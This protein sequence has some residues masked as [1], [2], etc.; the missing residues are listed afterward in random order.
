M[1]KSGITGFSIKIAVKQFAIRILLAFFRGLILVKRHF[2]PLLRASLSPLLSVGRFLV[3]VIGVPLY[4]VLFAVRRSI[5]RVAGPAKHRALYVVSN[6]YAIHV[7]VV[8]IAAVASTMN[9]G[10]SEVR[11]ESFGQN[12]ML[13][14]LV[15]QG[16]NETV[17][18]V[19]AAADV[20][21][22]K[23]ASYMD[24]V[25]VSADSHIDIGDA[26]SDF[27]STTVGGS[28]I[29]T[30]AIS[31][32]NDSVAPRTEVE[33]YTVQDGDTLSGISDQF[34]LSLSTLL[35]ANNLTFRSTIRPGD[36]LTIPPVD[37]VMYTVKKGDTIST[38]AKSY[39]SD[40]D[41][42]IAF[43]KL[44]SADDL[45]IG[46]QIMIPDGEPPAPPTVRRVAPI[47][48]LFTGTPS[49]GSSSSSSSASTGSTGTGGAHFIWPT[50]GHVITQYFGHLESWGS[51]HTG[52][53]IDGD[54][55]DHSFAAADGVVIF[56][57]WKNGYG[58]CI[59]IDH[60]N[61]YVTRYGHHSKLYVKK[62]EVV[63]AG[64][65]IGQIGTTGWSTGT[66]LHFEIIKNGKYQNPLNYIR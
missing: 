19:A 20:E 2:G 28:A 7:A 30:P 4:R 16:A 45:K 65:I 35:W 8:G 61:G 55:S 60:G 64:E 23:V 6:R 36:A 41:K 27:I 66:H 15:S 3:A 22:P 48:T 17:D 59:E 51:P 58:N 32:N 43:N 40:S 52:L 25:S 34:G 42:I 14:A 26:G 12:S 31:E 47:T 50:E 46:E 21:Q 49:S 37:G 57:G 18:V 62:G 56:S 33:T 39:S 10:G 38:I 24:D 11:A 1:R 63:T 13:Y 5:A 9:V 29:S 53:D 44:A 54:Y